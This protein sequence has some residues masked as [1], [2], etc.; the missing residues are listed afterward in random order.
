MAHAVSLTYTRFDHMSPIALALTTLLHV[1]VAAA[2]WWISPLNHVDPDA[3]TVEVTMEQEPT[4]PAPPETPPAAVP[5]PQA[6][7][8]P[9]PPQ[10]AA[11]PPPPPAAPPAPPIRLGL[12]PVGT[13]KDPQATPGVQQPTPAKPETQEEQPP[14]QEA[15]DPP[16]PDPPRPALPRPEQRQALAAPPPPPPPPP[17]LEKS[18]P[19]LEAPPPPL[20]AREIAP[21]A[22]P[23]APKPPPPQPPQRAQPAPRP[24]PAP[25][26][27]SSS[28]LSNV[29]QRGPGGQQASRQSPSFT[30]PADVFGQ[31]RAEDEYLWYV[32]RKVSQHQE[33]V[34]NATT[35]QGTVTLRLTI[36]RDGRLVE[37]GLAR[38]SGSQALDGASMNMVR[39]AG[40]YPP[41]PPEIQG[42]Q[43]TF[44]LPLYY[45]RN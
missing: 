6:A 14:P 8:P 31:K 28:P 15:I 32:A 33:F 5:P 42:G 3:D 40:P 45:K 7:E 25:Q 27:L 26:A 44:I 4:P 29:P 23:P 9:P 10:V 41:L 16:K 24:A 17:L 11:A 20:T 37:V 19:P 38:S 34:G 22:P 39:Q 30:N 18:L 35:D 1:S 13:K 36:A 12:P 2:L 43:H 21:P